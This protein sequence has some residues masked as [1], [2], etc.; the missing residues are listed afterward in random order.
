MREVADY[1]IPI[2]T[3]TPAVSFMEFQTVVRRRRMCRR[4]DTSRP[5]PHDLV[6]TLT[7]NALRAP[8][9]GFAQGWGFLVLERPEDIS[10]FR[11]AATLREDPPPWYAPAF[12]DGRHVRRS[13]RDHVLG[14]Q[15]AYLDRYA[16]PG[17]PPGQ[18]SDAWWP[19]PFWD[20]DA[21]FAALLILLTAVDHDLGA[22][23][24]GVPGT[25]A[26][27]IREL[28]PSRKSFRPSAP[29]RSATQT[30]TS[31]VSPPASDGRWPKWS[32][33]AAGRR[34]DPTHQRPHAEKHRDGAFPSLLWRGWRT[35]LVSARR[36]Q[37]LSLRRA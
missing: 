7:S 14:Q 37:Q 6:H 23:F 16:E 36:E 24:I 21:G 8:S 3:I 32:T 15:N 4:F 34:N 27:A 30:K 18:R 17:A 10:A 22:C 2:I 35:W 31:Q 19:A 33:V 1:P 26:G 20:I 5:V 25:R 13:P 28:F 29:S 9:A 12:P 11:D